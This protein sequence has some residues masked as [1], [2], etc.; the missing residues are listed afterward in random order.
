MPR[1]YTPPNVQNIIQGNWQASP[2]QAVFRRDEDFI[3]GS[4]AF[5]SHYWETHILAQHPE[6]AMI[7]SWIKYGVTLEQFLR[8]Q[9]P[10]RFTH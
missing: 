10:Y 8:L 4:L 2:K 3:A 7:L 9:I 5:C 6:K 1:T